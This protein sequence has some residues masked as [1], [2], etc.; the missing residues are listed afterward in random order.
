MRLKTRQLIA[1]L[2]VAVTSGS[3]GARALAGP[4][5]KREHTPPKLMLSLGHSGRAHAV[6]FSSDG[7]LAL[8]GGGEGIACLWYVRTGTE[9]RRLGPQGAVYYCAFS[10][11]GRTA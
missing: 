9:I 3:H 6:A 5:N 11:N 2:V 10:R 7:R 4:G 8:T 1:F